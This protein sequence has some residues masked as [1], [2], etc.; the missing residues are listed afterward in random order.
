LVSRSGGS[1]ATSGNQ[2]ELESDSKL[3]HLDQCHTEFSFGDDETNFCDFENG[4]KSS[5]DCDDGYPRSSPVKTF[6]PNLF[7]LYD[8]NGNAEEWTQDCW[9]DNYIGA[10]TSGIAWVEPNCPEGVLRGGNHL[11][12]PNVFRSSNRRKKTRASGFAEDQEGFRLASD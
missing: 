5:E 1:G 8:M 7:G 9:H 2:S 11:F 6:M 4:S 10:P 3:H 12:V